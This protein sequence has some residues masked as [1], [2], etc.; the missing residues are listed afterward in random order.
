[1]LHEAFTPKMKEGLSHGP[2]EQRRAYGLLATIVDASQQGKSVDEHYLFTTPTEGTGMSILDNRRL[3]NN[4][5]E[6]EVTYW[7]GAHTTTVPVSELLVPEARTTLHEAVDG[8]KNPA[9]APTL[10]PE[11]LCVDLFKDFHRD[12]AEGKLPESEEM[13]ADF[14]ADMREVAGGRGLSRNCA[15]N[16]FMEWLTP[17][18]R[19][20]VTSAMDAGPDGVFNP[21]AAA[22][23]ADAA[24][25]SP[26]AGGASPAVSPFVHTMAE[27]L[28]APG[29]AA[30]VPAPATPSPFASPHTGP[31][32]E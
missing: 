9:T 5:H 30:A 13:V 4:S 12:V 14:V 10:D 8:W 1:M 27:Q 22:A 23:T 20:V 15:A 16:D 18:G 19:N 24:V 31:A 11:N 32:V 28:T 7:K 21:H 17:A 3:G 25:S 26:T 6:I 29:A 2:I